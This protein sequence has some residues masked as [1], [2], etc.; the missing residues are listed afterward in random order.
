MSITFAESSGLCWLDVT[1]PAILGLTGAPSTEG[2]DQL[3][4]A[5]TLERPSKV[6]R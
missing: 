2:S 4:Y 5:L 1:L 6:A 3:T